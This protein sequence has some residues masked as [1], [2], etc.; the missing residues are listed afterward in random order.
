VLQYS[1]SGSTSFAK[2]TTGLLLALATPFICIILVFYSDPKHNPY[3][4]HNEAD[5]QL[6]GFVEQFPRLSEVA[7]VSSGDRTIST[8]G[9]LACGFGEQVQTYSTHLTYEEVV[10]RYRRAFDQRG[11][12]EYVHE[13]ETGEQITFFFNADDLSLYVGFRNQETT[14]PQTQ[15]RIYF[16]YCER[17]RGCGLCPRFGVPY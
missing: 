15:I 10:A 17:N 7:L 8:G 14:P 11:W 9:T 6:S 4:S 12:Q 3:I 13:S 2:V 5:R 16:E 1:E